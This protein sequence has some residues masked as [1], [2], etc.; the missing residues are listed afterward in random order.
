VVIRR[1]LQ[2]LHLCRAC[3]GAGGESPLPCDSELSGPR[4]LARE[5]VAEVGMP[6]FRAVE[7]ISHWLDA[8]TIL[9]RGAGA[10]ATGC[11][12]RK[13]GGPGGWNAVELLV[14]GAGE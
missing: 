1:R 14:A 11:P 4:V 7:R 2:V 10:P 3:V 6:A 8:S 13:Q 12:A 5:I 9:L